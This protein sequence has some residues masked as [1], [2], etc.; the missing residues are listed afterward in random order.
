M[1][2]FITRTGENDEFEFEFE[3]P[4]GHGTFSL[5][6][7]VDFSGR[8]AIS[9][10]MSHIPSF[11]LLEQLNMSNFKVKH[12]NILAILISCCLCEYYFSSNEIDLQ[13]SPGSKQ[14]SW[15]FL[16]SILQY[17]NIFHSRLSCI[18]ITFSS[19]EV[20]RPMDL[21]P[22]VG[23]LARPTLIKELTLRTKA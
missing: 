17:L 9:K 13:Q 12:S 6:N 22:P 16:H 18:K 15:S 21:A 23:A 5:A 7:L 2:F 10:T 19:L 4:H 1:Y 11:K 8:L 14:D 3:S 20:I